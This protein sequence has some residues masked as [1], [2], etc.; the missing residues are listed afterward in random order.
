MAILSVGALLL[1]PRAPARSRLGSAGVKRWTEA[2]GALSVDRLRERRRREKADREIFEAIGFVRNLIAARKGD[3]VSADLLLEELARMD[4]SLKPV[5]LKALSLLR[6][7]RKAEMSAYFSETAG[8]E[9]A[10]DFIRIIVQWDDVSPQKL[11]S[12]LLS[13]QNTMKERRT[14]ELKRKNELYSDLVFFPV[15][16]NVMAVFMNFIFIA[17]FIEQKD[18]LSQLFF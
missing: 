16:A 10:R 7:N 18:L 3:R 15:V 13:Y 1:T 4:G 14:T 17:Y 5:Y 12:T 2:A 9:A 11:S 6:V 8:T